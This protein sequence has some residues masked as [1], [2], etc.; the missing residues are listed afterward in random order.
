MEKISYR[1]FG[2]NPVQQKIDLTGKEGAIL[3]MFQ[4][5]I[6]SI[7]EWGNGIDKNFSTHN[8]R[9]RYINDSAYGEQWHVFPGDLLMYVGS[10]SFSS[11]RKCLFWNHY[12]ITLNGP[13]VK[14]VLDKVWVGPDEFF[15]EWSGQIVGD[16]SQIKDCS[17][18]CKN[19]F[20]AID[21]DI[22]F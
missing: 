11:T 9:K 4:G 3:Q 8:G 13:D 16:I 7:I 6:Y 17:L 10:D 1:D 18:L 20:S 22:D 19:Y 21:D 15:S 14:I 2:P 5:D 12:F